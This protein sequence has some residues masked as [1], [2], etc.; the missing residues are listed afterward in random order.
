VDHTYTQRSTAVWDIR[1]GWQRFNEPN[2]RQQE[3]S[4]APATLGFT[5]AVTALFGGAQY[6][7]HFTFSTIHDIGDNLG[8]TTT[9]TIYS[10]QPGYTKLWGNHS[11]RAGYDMRL[12]HEFSENPGR[13]AGEYTNSG[14]YTR[15]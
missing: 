4:F 11:L 12:Y 3:V 15:Q 10:F 9:H 2:V 1:A 5:P 8:G 13:Q 7:P 6:F 14:T